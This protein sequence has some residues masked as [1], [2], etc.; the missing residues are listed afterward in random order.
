MIEDKLK[1]LGIEL[2]EVPVP[3]GSYK[4]CVRTSGL[5]YVSGQLPI[6]N[7][8]L[9][10]NG[11]VGGE[12]SA[13]Q[14]KQAARQAAI[15]CVSVLKHELGHLEHVNRIVK[16]TGY[17]AS[18]EGFREQADIVNGASE[19]FFEV[20]GEKGVHARVAVGVFELP[21]GSPVE[22]E[23]IAEIEPEYTY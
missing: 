8:K 12:V 7:G 23:V 13:D 10:Y 14:G 22:I 20:F 19:L 6:K 18:T 4:P 5:I 2:S 11:K 1:E 16:V 9:L 21:K 15:N 3:L 17:I